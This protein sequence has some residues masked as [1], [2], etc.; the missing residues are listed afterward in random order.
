MREA[1]MPETIAR[2]NRDHA[3][4]SVL[5][6]LLERQLDLFHRGESPDYDLMSDI[7]FYM[8]HYTDAVHHPRE[9]LAFA[10][11]RQRDPAAE[12]FVA[13]LAEQH[14]RLKESGETLIQALD[15]I[16]NGSISPRERIELPGRAYIETFR[17]HMQREEATLLPLVA[18]LLHARDWS[19]IDAAVRHLEDPLF[20]SDGEQRYA[21][22]REQIAREAHGS[23]PTQ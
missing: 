14:A 1:T 8:A 15:D 23:S 22:L 2:W 16:I 13:E 19:A 3:N 17:K 18:K 21:A 9:D 20:G 5:L 6:G 4:F 12:P 11:L 10:K 7:M